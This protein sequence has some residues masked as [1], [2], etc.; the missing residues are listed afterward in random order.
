LSS[1]LVLASDCFPFCASVLR[2]E[3]SLSHSE[4]QDALQEVA[5][6]SSL[7][8]IC[9]FLTLCAL[10]QPGAYTDQN[11]L[12]L[13]ELLCRAGLD[14]R[15]RLLPKTDLQQL[16]LQLLENIREWPE[17]LRQLC[18]ALSRASDHHH[19][20]LALVQLFLDVSPRSRQ[21]RGQLSLLV[22]A[23]LLNQQ[24]RLSL[25]QEKAQVSV[26]LSILWGLGEAGQPLLPLFLKVGSLRPGKFKVGLPFLLT[27]LH[28]TVT[29]CTP[30]LCQ[31]LRI[32]Q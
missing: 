24:E 15:L 8:Y 12:D 19:N 11:L 29:F 27:S 17:K 14:T 32:K 4:Q 10:A 18:C 28:L 30:T 2:S 13:I 25:W 3:A 26:C 23:R 21:L 9:K 6:D 22:M 1:S 31:P 7:N 20:L 16:L 5:L